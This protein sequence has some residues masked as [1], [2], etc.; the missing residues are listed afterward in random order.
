MRD[1]NV[2]LLLWSFPIALSL[3][4]F[5][6][7]AFPGGLKQWIRAYK[8]RKPKSD[9]Y[10]F[11]VNAAA[12]AAAIIIASKASDIVGVRIYLYFVAAMAGNAASHIR[13]TIQKKQ[14]C[15]GTVSSGLLLLP[16]FV[17]SFW[18]FLGVG[19]VDLPSALVCSCV[20][21]VL[22]FCVFGMDIRKGDRN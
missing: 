20:G 12:I 2:I 1:R 6:E 11:V 13:G 16:L 22:G 19:K 14:Y 4:V 3:H 5:E 21:F 15:P 9:F 17:I 8:P 18:Y 7:F 10:Y